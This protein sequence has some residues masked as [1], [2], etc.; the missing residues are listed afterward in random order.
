MVYTWDRCQQE[1]ESPIIERH[2]DGH[3]YSIFSFEDGSMIRFLAEE[4]GDGSFSPCL[5]ED[6]EVLEP[7]EGLE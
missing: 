4:N 6:M 1:C 5:D 2:F 7:M 3:I